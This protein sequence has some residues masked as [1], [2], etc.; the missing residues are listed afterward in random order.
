M[1]HETKMKLKMD[2][3]EKSKKQAVQCLQAMDAT[4]EN[5]TNPNSW[6]GVM[7]MVSD[8]MQHGDGD[9]KSAAILAAAKWTWANC[10]CEIHKHLAETKEMIEKEVEAAKE[11]AADGDANGSGESET[12]VTGAA[13]VTTISGGLVM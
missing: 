12:P 7:Q 8:A 5:G 6:E 10:E 2:F 1:T 9:K 4:V 3:Y 13:P 11:P